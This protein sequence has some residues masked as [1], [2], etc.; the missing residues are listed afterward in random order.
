MKKSEINACIIAGVLATG[1]F[2][3]GCG[4]GSGGG[5]GGL[6]ATG[7]T[8]TT[9][10][11]GTPGGSGLLD[12]LGN[13]VSIEGLLGN[14]TGLRLD[15]LSPTE[16]ARLRTEGGLGNVDLQILESNGTILGLNTPNGAFALPNVTLPAGVPTLPV[17]PA[18]IGNILS[19][20]RLP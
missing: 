18:N 5:M 13:G 7:A 10:A 8:G 20:I 14:D 15:A 12:S 3:T 1:V 6:G 4:G 2:L 16:L 11:P 9:G 17:L 19:G